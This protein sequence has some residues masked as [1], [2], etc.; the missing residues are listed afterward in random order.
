MRKRIALITTWYPPHQGVAVQRMDAFAQ[1]LSIDYEVEVFTL[2]SASPKTYKN[3]NN[4]LVHRFSEPLWLRILKHNTADHKVMHHFKTICKIILNAL[5]SNPLY[6]WTKHVKSK[7]ISIHKQKPFDVLLSS[8]SPVQPHEI[9]IAIKTIYPSVLWIADMRDEM[10]LNTSLTF[11]QKQK[12]SA[13]EKQ[14]NR[15][16]DAI[17]SVSDPLVKEFEI[18]CPNVNTFLTVQ[19]G[20][21]HDYKF[22]PP[23]KTNTTKITWGYFG[24][25]YGAR[26]PD[27]FFKAL[28]DVQQEIKIKIE[29]HLFGVHHN[30]NIPE[31]LK[32]SII[33]HPALSYNDTI[34]KMHEMDF[35]LLIHPSTERKGI[36]TGKL[37]DY[38][39]V[40][41]P[42][43]AIIDAHDVAAQLITT[44]DCGYI[45]DFNAVHEIKTQVYCIVQD[46]MRCRF[47][48]ASPNN[49][50]LL[51]RNVQIEK[52]KN[53][54]ENV[55]A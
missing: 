21:N 38:I 49:I 26:K 34:K 47:K 22:E 13:V 8:F 20:Y 25:F 12:L 46:I 28:L 53:Y 7:F 10:S 30:F 44:Y 36:F 51:H 54:I 11:K 17:I 37:F 52:I 41:R 15:W 6:G 45:A 18:L 40:Q 31:T 1:Y 3:T 24:T 16:A 29:G 55:L 2:E 42:I 23:I 33:I 39:S 27:V 5:I 43:L 32:S 9:A 19:N 14:V 50:A 4:I 35:N 48:T